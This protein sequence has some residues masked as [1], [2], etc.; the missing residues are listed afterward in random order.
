MTGHRFWAYKCGG[1]VANRI[2]DGQEGSG[3]WGEKIM[4]LDTQSKLPTGIELEVAVSR[5]QFLKLAALLGGT[6][7]SAVLLEACA[8]SSSNTTKAT[9]AATGGAPAA[10]TS[11]GSAA[12]GGAKLASDQTLR[13]VGKEPI[14]M[15]PGLTTALDD[16]QYIF[17]VWE[18]LLD[19]DEKG[20]PIPLG[21]TSWE[22]SPDGV[23]YTFHLR[24]GVR[25]TDGSPVTAKDYEWTWK[26]N[27][28]PKTGSEY[29]QAL[30]NVKGAQEFNLGKNPDRDSVGVKA[31]DDKTL[32][33][34]LTGPAG[35]FLRI[36]ST[37]TAMPLPRQ[38]IEKFG[39]KWTD[40]GNVI[41]NGPFKIQK[42]DHDQQIVLARNEA[43]WGPKPTLD[44]VVVTITSDYTKTS[45]PGYENNELDYAIGPWPA[46]IDRINS[47]PKLSK[48]LHNFP[49]SSTVF[50]TCDTTNSNSPVS[51]PEV[52]R[53]LY[54]A[55]DREKMAN[56]VLKKIYTPAYTILPQDILGYNPG[57]RIPG[58]VKEAKD[59]LAAGG[60]PDGKGMPALKI[61]Y[62]QRSDRDLVSQALQ[63]MWKDNL[64]IKVELNPMES[65]AYSAYRKSLKTGHFDMLLSNWG[66]DYLDPFD[67]HNFLFMT[68]TDFYHAH[69]SNADF[70]KLASQAATLT[71]QAK[72]KDLHQQAEAILVK[73]A[74]QIPIYYI[75]IP[76]LIKPW[77]TGYV[78][79]ALAFDFFRNVK[80][81]QHS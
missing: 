14:H 3:T 58:G 74:S 26:R 6:G 69:W 40:A 33:V 23:T 27:E 19:F 16:L 70:D 54:L 53:A 81:Q 9:N 52:R 78:H 36:A 45:L 42:W 66:S 8:T 5:R 72:R 18:G 39:D 29:A 37:W 11:S 47:D 38:S 48:E 63:Q 77:V 1:K 13:Y 55:I 24:D 31:I 51:K 32:Q 12:A 57:A 71:D 75:S 2:W 67:W 34:T 4:R 41:S 21:A 68:D 76:Y 65:K 35:Y 56:D 44:K 79:T 25:W 49:Y 60:F 61:A 73:D 7:A 10:G 15:D 28:D 62:P 20:N 22:I 50:L 30:Y 17:N 46:D 80:I 43:Y 59:A 64:G